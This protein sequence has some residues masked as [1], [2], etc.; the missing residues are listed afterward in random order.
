M[1]VRC[2]VT[3]QMRS[4]Q[5]RFFKHRSASR[6]PR[7]AGKTPWGVAVWVTLAAPGPLVHTGDKILPV[8][9]TII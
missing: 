6:L 7:P 9:I 2:A 1:K 3:H 5:I 8:I 4:T